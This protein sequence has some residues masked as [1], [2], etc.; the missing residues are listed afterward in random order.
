[1]EPYAEGG[2]RSLLPPFMQ[3]GG[4][5]SPQLWDLSSAAHH[6]EDHSL[7][8]AGSYVVQ[9]GFIVSKESRVG[10][11]SSCLLPPQTPDLQ[12]CATMPGLFGA[13][14]QPQVLCTLDKHSI[15][16]AAPRAL[17]YY[18]SIAKCLPVTSPLSPWSSS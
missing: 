15:H 2:G 17:P 7:S 9:A 10:P 3:Q 14:D 12:A 4:K 13:V 1:M 6:R 18:F 11:R 5:P 16:Q 8:E